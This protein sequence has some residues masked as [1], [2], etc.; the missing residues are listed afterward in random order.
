[1]DELFGLLRNY[2]K[3]Y[4]TPESSLSIRIV[5]RCFA[6]TRRTTNMVD[7]LSVKL[8]TLHLNFRIRQSQTALSNRI[9]ITPHAY[10]TIVANARFFNNDII[11]VPRMSLT[12]GASTLIDVR[13]VSVVAIGHF[14]LTNPRRA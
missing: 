14:M 8:K 5:W 13:E 2:Q 4:C 3:S 11:T 9:H 6:V 12:V 7:L 1:M 10:A